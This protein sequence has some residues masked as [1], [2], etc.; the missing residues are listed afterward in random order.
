VGAEK[1]YFQRLEPLLERN[2][3]CRKATLE[4]KVGSTEI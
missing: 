4:E 3:A 1:K 2:P